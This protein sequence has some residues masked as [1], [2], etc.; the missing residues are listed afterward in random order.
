M[1][2]QIES[3]PVLTFRK[4][5]ESFMHHNTQSDGYIPIMKT[6]TD[7]A[8]C[9]LQKSSNKIVRREDFCMFFQHEIV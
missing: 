7:T 2:V 3:N 8:P 4:I 5:S 6:T 9:Q 1:E